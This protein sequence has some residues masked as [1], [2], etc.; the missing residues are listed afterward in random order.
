[1]VEGRQVTAVVNHG[2]THPKRRGPDVTRAM[3]PVRVGGRGGRSPNVDVNV[4]AVGMFNQTAIEEVRALVHSNIR[5][6][7]DTK[8]QTVEVV[9]AIAQTLSHR[10]QESTQS[11]GF[12]T[13]FD[14][15]D[16]AFFDDQLN[17]LTEIGRYAY[18][19]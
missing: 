15:C 18:I 11:L 4:G 10:S 5:L 1:M 17:R 8:V 2:V 16:S 13:A 14:F 6:R 19:A 3:H 7:M 12:V 9:D